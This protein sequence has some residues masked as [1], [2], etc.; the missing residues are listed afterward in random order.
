MKKRYPIILFMSLTCLYT[1]IRAQNNVAQV[2]ALQHAPKIYSAKKIGSQI[3]IDGKME[4]IWNTAT[5]SSQFLDIEDN[6]K[7]KP[8]FQTQYKM[9]WDDENLYIYAKL[10]EP[11]IWGTLQKH[12][13]II[14]HDNDFEVFL[15][16]NIASPIYYEIE[17]NTLNTIMDLMMP[18]PYR[19][20]GQALMHWDVKKLKSAVYVEGTLNDPSDQDHYWVVEMAIP[21]R[22]LQKFGSSS[23]PKINSFWRINFSRVQWQH[24]VN[25]G[26]Y[27]R[28]KL[29]GKHIPEDNWVWSPI[30]LVNMH[31]PERWGFLRFVKDEDSTDLPPFYEIEKT[32]WNIHYL[33]HIYKI[34]QQKFTSDLTK[35]EG[36]SILLK[37]YLN[38]YKVQFTISSDKKF[39]HLI[40]KEKNSKYYFT[41]DSYG[42]YTTNYE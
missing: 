17:V 5:W 3:E 16:P 24:D 35:L 13:A 32:A 34:E 11:H 31:Y 22:S 19:M 15:K 14:Y 9:L 21:F 39:Y 41:I 8:T 29:N 27:S 23:T 1:P 6:Q 36:F 28:K 20:G 10:Q 25:Q 40:L 33:Q 7:P 4:S 38:K 42:N 26:T 2:E 18:K 12:D 37:K 30:G